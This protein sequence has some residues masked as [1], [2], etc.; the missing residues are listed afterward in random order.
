LMVQLNWNYETGQRA[1]HTIDAAGHAAISEQEKAYYT[2]TQA[3]EEAANAWS[4]L[5]TARQ[6]LEFLSDQ[7]EIAKRFLELA[8]KERELGRRTLLDVLQGEVNLINAQ[9]D[10]T[11]AET[12]VVL[13]GF[14]VL[15]ACGR[16][17]PGQALT[18]A[19]K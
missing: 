8:R 6:R 16:L 17:N 7:V 1:S 14:R 5:Q 15:R 9:S 18:M 10:A 3:R 12:D 11:A 4:D 2:L 13:A 19:N